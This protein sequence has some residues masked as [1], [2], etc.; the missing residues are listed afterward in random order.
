M[1][2]WCPIQLKQKDKAGRPDIDLFET[3]MRRADR[4]KGFFVGFDYTDDA[5]AGIDRF[6]RKTGRVIT[7]LTVQEILDEELAKKLA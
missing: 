4:K 3:A 6:F 5:L 1:G 7:A 2:E